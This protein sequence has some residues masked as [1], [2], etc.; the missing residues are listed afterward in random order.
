MAH[1]TRSVKAVPI[2]AIG[3]CLL[4]FGGPAPQAAPTTLPA[5]AP[6]VDTSQASEREQ[7]MKVLVGRLMQ[8]NLS[9]KRQ[10]EESLN[11]QFQLSEQIKALKSK[12]V[13]PGWVGH[14]FN[15]TEFYTLPV[16]SRGSGQ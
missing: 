11:K 13:P 1:V 8:E 3:L 15:G 2:I 4:A 14:E 16:N 10:L 12:A 7:Q 5:K 9:L 6:T